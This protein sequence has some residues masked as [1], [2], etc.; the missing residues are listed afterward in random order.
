MQEETLQVDLCKQLEHK[1]NVDLGL[2]WW[3]Q[4]VASAFWSNISTPLNLAITL[5]TAITTAQATTNNL[6]PHDVYVN[7][8]IAT[9]ILSVINTFFRPHTQLSENI[10]IMNEY[11][12]FG[13]RFEKIIYTPYI[14]PEDQT[15]RLE[16]LRQLTNDMNTYKNALSPDNRN[17][18]T[19]LIYI[20]AK[21][22]ILR[23]HDKW[24]DDCEAV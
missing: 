1:L 11:G 12:A 6:L 13:S 4:Y 24:L 18:M 17:F 2:Y 19:D 23:Q 16:D 21:Y 15:R 22:T 7:I 20:V 14:T 5:M 10:K 9:L 8:N 3:K